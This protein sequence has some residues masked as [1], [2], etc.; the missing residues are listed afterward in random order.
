MVE[1]EREQDG[2]AEELG[3]RRRGEN[4]MDE[5][6]I[7]RDVD[8]R[9]CCKLNCLKPFIGNVK[10]VRYLRK[11][12][13]IMDKDKDRRDALARLET[14]KE[15]SKRVQARRGMNT[16]LME[17]ELGDEKLYMCVAGF[18]QLLGISKNLWRLV[19]EDARKPHL[20][21]HEVQA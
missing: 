9:Q 6:T 12:Y 17:V 13:A 7:T 5:A 10:L 21:A 1:W 20:E 15:H 11:P 16:H 2:G 3:F 18:K 4:L 8:G 14:V 19:L